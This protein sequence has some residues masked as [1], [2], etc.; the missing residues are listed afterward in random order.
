MG[1]PPEQ[2]QAAQLRPEE[3]GSTLKSPESA[4][5]KRLDPEKAREEEKSRLGGV[6]QTLG[7]KARAQI[8]ALSFMMITSAVGAGWHGQA[9][10]AEKRSRSP[11]E[12]LTQEQTREE[13][14]VKKETFAFTVK[15]PK[16]AWKVLEKHGIKFRP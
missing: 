6:L 7:D 12:Q 15:V 1:I 11:A 10:A 3:E 16:G 8:A 13:F 5:E 4:E 9:S 14:A 2:E